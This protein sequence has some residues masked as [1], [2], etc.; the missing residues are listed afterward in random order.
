MV[1]VTFS[2]D[3]D[4]TTKQK[5]MSK[6]QTQQLARTSKALGDDLNKND[7]RFKAM[8]CCESMDLP[9]SIKLLHLK[10]MLCHNTKAE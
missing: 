4:S 1:N 2:L 7:H 3:V 10:T 9:S 8:F 6:G 5:N